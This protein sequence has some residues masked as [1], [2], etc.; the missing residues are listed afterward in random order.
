MRVKS[1]G[2]G[3]IGW[4]IRGLVTG[5]ERKLGVKA[6][7]LKSA[8]PPVERKFVVNGGFRSKQAP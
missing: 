7:Q 1:M 3:V 4:G 8:A 2:N 6:V 5:H